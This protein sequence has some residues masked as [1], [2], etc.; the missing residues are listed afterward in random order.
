MADRAVIAPGLLAVVRPVA[1]AFAAHGHELHLVGGIV[2]DQLLDADAAWSDLDC[3]TDARPPDIKR[4]IAPFADAVWTQ[5]ERFGTI[6]CRIAGEAWEITTYR[7]EAYD[8]ASRKP[9]VVFAD[10]LDH[11]LSRRDFTINAM[12]VDARTGAMHDPFGGRDDLERRVLR[13]PSGAEL[14]FSDDPLRMLRAARFLARFAL[15][16]APDLDLAIE[17]CRDRLAIVSVERVRDE[18]HKLLAVDDPTAGLRFL[19]DHRLL[20]RWLPGLAV[21]AGIVDPAHGDRDV[22][23]HTLDVVRAAPDRPVVRLAA[24]LHDLAKAD[25]IAGHVTRG[26]ALATD[27]LGALRHARHEV[28][29]VVA[30]VAAHHRVHDVD[31][32]WTPAATRAVLADVD[33]AVDDLVALSFADAAARAPEQAARCLAAVEGFVAVRRDL[34][35]EGDDLTPELDGDDVMRVLGIGPGRAVGEALAHLRARLVAR[36]RLDRADVAEELRAW[37]ATR[38]APA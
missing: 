6:G 20:E 13:T 38:D 28:R 35:T 19:V 26:A 5:G 27:T 2:R 23:T 25:G 16:P 31:A 1:D 32:P 9:R 37:W 33:G 29:D 34:G 10:A 8:P 17:H 21:L 22:L 7:G 12:A 15:T 36:G 3:T 24:L 4:I 11:D 30:L 18:L 14:S